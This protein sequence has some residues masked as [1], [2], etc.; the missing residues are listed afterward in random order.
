MKSLLGK[1]LL[2]KQ[3]TG[4]KIPSHTG[5]YFNTTLVVPR[6][7][8]LLN[9]IKVSDSVTKTVLLVLKTDAEFPA[10]KHVWEIQ[11]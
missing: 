7:I 10:G 11:S 1:D 3:S 9:T 4:I 5:N 8:V 2:P 6:I